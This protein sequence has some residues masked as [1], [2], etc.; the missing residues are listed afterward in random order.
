MKYCYL[1]W[2]LIKKLERN[3]DSIGFHWNVGITSGLSNF[4]EN[5][6]T[7]KYS[8]LVKSFLPSENFV[9]QTVFYFTK[10]GGVTDLVLGFTNLLTW[11]CFSERPFEPSL[12]FPNI[13]GFYLHEGIWCWAN[14]DKLRLI[15]Y[16]LIPLIPLFCTLSFRYKVLLSSNANC[17]YRFLL[18]QSILGAQ[19]FSGGYSGSGSS[20]FFSSQM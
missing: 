4:T 18:F 20:V 3:H 16:V 2:N 7:Y 1:C 17:Y 11:C 12:S 10:Y 14:S 13:L 15:L 19:R 5:L 8:I 9:F 6:K